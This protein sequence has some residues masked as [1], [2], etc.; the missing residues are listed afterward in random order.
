[1]V[2][3]SDILNGCCGYTNDDNKVVFKGACKLLSFLFV[4]CG[5]C[6]QSQQTDDADCRSVAVRLH[7]DSGVSKR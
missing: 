1:M 2:H 4:D 3:E 7:V 6:P 5:L